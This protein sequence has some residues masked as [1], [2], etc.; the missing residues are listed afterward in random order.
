[1]QD[2]MEHYA[3]LKIELQNKNEQIKQL[4]KDIAVVDELQS[5]VKM[6][7]EDLASERQ[8]STELELAVHENQ[9][10]ADDLQRQLTMVRRKEGMLK[11]NLNEQ[12]N[13]LDKLKEA[14]RNKA[15]ENTASLTQTMIQELEAKI[16]SLQY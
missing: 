5:L 15:S 6:L 1:M 10:A 2:E 11:Q 12:T 16:R 4:Q 9:N 14:N 7:K 8:R 3:E 13:E